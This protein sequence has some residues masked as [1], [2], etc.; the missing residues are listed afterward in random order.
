MSAGEA[1]HLPRVLQ[2]V[3]EIHF[4]KLR[5]KPGMPT[6]FGQ[7]GASVYFGLPSNPVA[8]AVIFRVFV[9]FA[10]RAM[11]GLGDISEPRHAR[12]SAPLHERHTW[13]ELARCS[14]HTDEEGVLWAM[15]HAKRGSGMLRGL[16]ETEALALL[17]EGAREY[18]PG[19]VVTLWPE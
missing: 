6:L 9:H 18:R 13:A 4:H 11:L 12:L 15:L 5:F 10:L 14:L 1:D 8:S 16:A 19:D 7:I 17:P 2:R 3:G